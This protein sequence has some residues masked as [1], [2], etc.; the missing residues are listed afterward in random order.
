MHSISYLPKVFIS[1]AQKDHKHGGT[2]L[3]SVVFATLDFLTC[4]CKSRTQTY[5]K[6]AKQ[7]V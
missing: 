1:F 4:T 3:I 7:R 2:K 6:I 5:P